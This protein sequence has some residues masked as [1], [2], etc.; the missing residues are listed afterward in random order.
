M[1]SYCRRFQMQLVIIALVLVWAVILVGAWLGWQLL[2][3]NGRLLLR[4]DELEKRLD[5]LEFGGAD[6]PEGLPLGTEAPA[7]EL[8]DLAGQRKSLAQLRGQP[9]LL[10][11]FNPACGFCRELAPKL[12]TLTLLRTPSP[13]RWEREGVRAVRA[14]SS[15]VPVTQSRTVN[16]SASTN[17]VAPSSSKRNRNWPRRTKPTAHPAVT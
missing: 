11:F 9:L 7:F 10:I 13:I 12:A 6:E 4:L 16:C 14:C 5:E 15:S 17:S 8:A 2:R 1:V 3:Q